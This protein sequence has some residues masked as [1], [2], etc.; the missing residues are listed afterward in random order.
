MFVEDAFRPLRNT[1]KVLLLQTTLGIRIRSGRLGSLNR[2][3]HYRIT[4]AR[5][6]ANRFYTSMQY[7]LI[8]RKWIIM[9]LLARYGTPCYL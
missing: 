4:H 1:W 2:Y 6:R 5:F 9:T 7:S 8:R 3:V